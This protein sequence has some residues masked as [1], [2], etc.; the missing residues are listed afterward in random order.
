MPSFCSSLLECPSGPCIRHQFRFCHWIR[1]IE[2]PL[3]VRV[4]SIS[5]DLQDGDVQGVF[6]TI[7]RRRWRRTCQLLTPHI[8]TTRSRA[9]FYNIYIPFGG[10]ELAMVEEG[11]NHALGIVKEQ[12]ALK[13]SSTLLKNV[14]LYYTVIGSNMTEEISQMCESYH[15]RH[16]SDEKQSQQQSQNCHLLQYSPQGDEALTLQ[17]IHDYCLDHPHDQITYIHNK[18]SFHPSEKNEKFRIFVNQGVLG[19]NGKVCQEMPLN[20]LQEG[21]LCL[22]ITWLVICGLP[23]VNM[24]E[25]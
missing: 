16:Q 10:E 15:D 8:N 3:E 4:I 14:P 5:D 13:Q 21:G 7:T 22:I 12:L 25:N 18:G 6:L 20:Q 19:R 9:V 17:S 24:Y 1:S 23:H 11:Q 2:R